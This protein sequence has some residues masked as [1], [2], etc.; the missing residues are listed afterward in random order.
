M[1]LIGRLVLTAICISFVFM[2]SH[3]NAYANT[4]QTAKTIKDGKYYSG[5]LTRSNKEMYFKSKLT[6]EKEVAMYLSEG[7]A[8]QW[9]LEVLD[10][11]GVTMYTTKTNLESEMYFYKKL[12]KKLPK[13]TYYLK[14]TD[15]HGTYNKKFKTTIRILNY[16]HKEKENNN[17]IKKAN[18]IRLN[19]KYTGAIDFKS[20]KADYYKFKIPSS[21]R[22]TV[23]TSNMIESDWIVGLLDSKGKIIDERYTDHNYD[24]SGF[25][26][27]TMGLKKGTYYIR[28]SGYGTD[29]DTNYIFNVKFKKD[30][31]VETEKNDT[32]KTANTIKIGKT[33]TG[34]YNEYVDPMDWYKYKMTKTSKHR[35]DLTIYPYSGII[36][37][38]TNSK[39]K[40]LSYNVYQNY[41]KKT[42]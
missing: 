4:Q 31:Y 42:K 38:I 15:N 29:D 12:V 8:I 20:D 10:S 24:P 19:D 14:V 26:S 34:W 39:H 18:T 16:D 25:T 9:N 2:F 13:G 1:K 7:W 21:G 6:S 3:N 37:Y 27:Y 32:Y 33:Y 36:V 5:K 11:S 28:I 22:V 23:S 40:I 17:S 41:T 35:L 30:S